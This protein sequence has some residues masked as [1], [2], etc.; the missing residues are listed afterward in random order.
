MDPST[1]SS[2][3]ASL[4][5]L[6]VAAL[7]SR[8]AAEMAA[9]IERFGGRPFVSPSMREVPIERNAAAV[10]FAHRLITG[11]V[12]IVI[13]MTG[14]GFRLLLSAVEKHLPRQ[15]YLDALADIITVARGPKPVAA[16]KEVGLVPSHRVPAPHTWREVLTTLDAHVP[17][18]HQVVGLQEY[19][20]TNSSLV[21]GLEARGACVIQVP[22]YRWELPEDIRPLEENIRRIA[23]NQI[24]VLLVTSAHQMVNLFRA[25]QRL[26]LADTLRYALRNVVVASIG[27]TTSEMLRELDVPVDIEPAQHKMGH[28]VAAAAAEAHEKLRAKRGHQQTPLIT[29][30]PAPPANSTA[31]RPAWQDSVFMKACRREPVPY[32]PIWLMRQAG[33]YMEEYRAIRRNVPFLELCRNPQLCSEVMCTAVEKLG[34]DAAIVFSDLLPILEPMG[35]EL[36]FQA[37]EGPVIQNPVRNASDVDRVQEL[38]SLE[39]LEFIRDVV[40]QTRHDLPEKI[41]L[42]GFG[43]S[44]FTLASYVIEGGASRNYIHTKTLMYRDPLAWQELMGRLGRAVVRWLRAQVESGAQALQIFDSWVG[45][46]SPTDFR[47]FV[48]PYIQ[49]VIRNLPAG[50]PIIYFATGNPSL[51]PWMAESGATV[52]GVD[53][54]IE[55]RDAWSLVGHQRAI[56]G[57]LDPAVLLAPVAEI[58]RRAEQILQ[59]AA[60]RPGH[61]FNLGHGVLPETPVE[62]ARALV[63]AV[64]ELSSLR[65]E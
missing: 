44:P 9:L 32:T 6:R 29:L 57:N 7:E 13:F 27:P 64:H 53:W 12:T 48:L 45:C 39:R 60:G 62:H 2:S 22:V 19:G 35:L 42:I 34:V 36:E 5:G 33:R 31:A 1:P 30:A 50:V 11:E 15:R 58:R 65:D 21:A 18:S 40:R 10:D 26:H 41:P 49:D 14:V 59:Q 20:V 54:R 37:G 61:I 55:L 23:D 43:G 52:L 3:T 51:L 46:L 8:R 63:E 25:A 38:E 56:Q 4:G 17:L 47:R 28:L 16:M 24:D